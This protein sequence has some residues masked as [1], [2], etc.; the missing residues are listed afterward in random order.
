MASNQ[1]RFSNFSFLALLLIS[2][3]S[4]TLNIKIRRDSTNTIIH[5]TSSFNETLIKKSKHNISDIRSSKFKDIQNK[6]QNYLKQ[7]DP[8]FLVKKI[9]EKYKE[10][11][12]Y[13][14]K[15]F[16]EKFIDHF[17][18]AETSKYLKHQKVFPKGEICSKENCLDQ[19]GTCLS[20][21]ICRCN[22]GWADLTGSAIT[23]NYQQRF[24]KLAL[25]SEF[26]LP[27][28]VGH[29]YCSRV[30]VGSI[31]FAVLFLIPFFCFLLSKLLSKLKR[32]GFE[33]EIYFEDKDLTSNLWK[34]IIMLFYLFA[35]S[36]WFVFDMAMFSTNI[37]KDGWGYDL[38]KI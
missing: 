9:E 8:Y 10:I 26:V 17:Q 29:L 4:T 38:I 28:G 27:F 36:L 20:I 2:A 35:F 7:K 19:N 24:Q 5:H 22:F 12:D 11:K 30:L 25:L 6:F 37:Y 14:Q 16:L 23:C 33:S 21:K 1:L 32:K 3:F 31:K 15:N 18:T 13:T 34:K